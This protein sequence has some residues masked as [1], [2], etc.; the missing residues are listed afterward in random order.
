MTDQP[1]RDMTSHCQELDELGYTILENALTA[2]QVAAAVTTLREVYERDKDHTSDHESMTQRV[3]NLTARAEVFRQMIQ[4]PE[5]VACMSYLLGDDYILCDM[6]ARSAMPGLGAQALHRDGADFMPNP[7]YDVHKILPL[8]TQSMI[9]LSDFT[10]EN[11]ATRYVPGSHLMDIHPDDIPPEDE[12]R[13]ICPAGTILIYDARLYHAGGA[14]TSDKIR[15][16]V[17]GFCCRKNIKPFCDH[18]RSIPPD[19]VENGI[20]LAA[21]VVIQVPDGRA[22]WRSADLLVR[23]GGFGVVALDLGAMDKKANLPLAVQSRLAGLAKKHRA[24]LLFLTERTA[25]DVTVQQSS[26]PHPS[27]LGP[28][29]S[30]HVETER[31]LKIGDRYACELHVLKDKH[32]HRSPVHPSWQEQ[33]LCRVPDG[34]C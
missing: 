31:A 28:L 29:I 24:A 6:G 14:N 23:S 4:L 26:S 16:A 1:E 11:G 17:Q 30:L 10:L 27:S 8:H 3:F 22:A 25:R 19:I 21:L 7:P 9:A 32:G 2:E 15:Y 5:V 12:K 33:E 18:T 13:L 34:L 20:D